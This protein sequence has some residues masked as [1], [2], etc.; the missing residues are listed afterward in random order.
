MKSFD[1]IHRRAKAGT[2]KGIAVSDAAGESVLC[3]LRKAVD[4]G[5]C[6]PWLV[7]DP[8]RI[9]PLAEAVGLRSFEILPALGP[10][11]IA[12]ATVS[13]VRDGRCSLLMKG[14]SDTKTLMQAVLDKET[15]LRTG[16]RMS[17]VAAV[18]V[19]AYPKVFFIT[20][21]GINPKPDL[22]VKG[23][24]ITNAVE[25]A[26]GLGIAAP[27]VAVLC[28]QEAVKEDQPET[29][30]ARALCEQ[31]AS[32]AFPQVAALEGPMA[33]DVAFSREAAAKKG[34]ESSVSGDA[35]IMVVPD[36]ASGNIMA[37]SILYLANGARF[38]GVVM[39]AACPIILLS[40]ADSEDEKFNSIALACGM[41]RD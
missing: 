34:I 21:G 36:L 28:A 4:E 33:T 19:P 7:G 29:I 6:M 10:E 25:A 14:K 27:K 16:R 38:G 1:D 35:D 13:L 22:A 39:G 17:H 5:L 15:G 12:R 8:A 20:D 41:V 18:E 2:P 40:R 26:S 24:I 32:G 3:A 9:E 23:M 37:K 31:F 11:E 30:D